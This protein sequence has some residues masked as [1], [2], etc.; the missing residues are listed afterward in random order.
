LAVLEPLVT[1]HTRAGSGGRQRDRG[2]D[3]DLLADWLAGKRRERRGGSYNAALT[4][5]ERGARVIQH[6]KQR[7][8]RIALANGPVQAVGGSVHQSKIS[9]GDELSAGEDDGGHIV[10]G[11]VLDGPIDAIRRGEDFAAETRGDVHVVAIGH[12][13]D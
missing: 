7:E 6:A 3:T 1:E 5:A 13:I 4:H 10:T 2:T 8:G 9:G 12:V 11:A